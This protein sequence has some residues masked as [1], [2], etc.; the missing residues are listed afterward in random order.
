M[1]DNDNDNDHRCGET[2]SEALE[3]ELIGGQIHTAD[4]LKQEKGQSQEPLDVTE[5]IVEGLTP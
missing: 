5:G 4:Q 3:C 1:N 2:E